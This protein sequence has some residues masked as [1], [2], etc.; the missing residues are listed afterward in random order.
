[1]IVVTSHT[2][3]SKSLQEILKGKI[4]SKFGS[5]DVQFAVDP[6][7]ILGLTIQVGDQEYYHNLDFELSHILNQLLNQV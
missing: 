3:L 6:S 5:G 2:P 1:M 4:S 7:L